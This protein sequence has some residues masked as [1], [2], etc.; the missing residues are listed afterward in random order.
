M[1]GRFKLNKKKCS[2]WIPLS[3]MKRFEVFNPRSLHVESLLQNSCFYTVY[4]ITMKCT[5]W[6]MARESDILGCLMCFSG[7]TLLGFCVIPEF[8]VIR[9]WG[10]SW[11]RFYYFDIL[12]HL[13]NSYLDRWVLQMVSPFRF[14]RKRASLCSSETRCIYWY[15]PLGL[16][17][18]Y[19]VPHFY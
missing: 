4:I 8:L 13:C 9:L 6:L 11:F 18:C 7:G 2:V 1:V 5:I 12:M 10:C 17:R 16:I 19:S 15:R 14:L 3:P